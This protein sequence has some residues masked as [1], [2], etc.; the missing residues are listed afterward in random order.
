MEIARVVRSLHPWPGAFTTFRGD[1]LKVHAAEP[2]GG[3]LP[4]GAL[5]EE[6]GAIVVG[7]GSGLL[8]LVEVQIAGKARTTGEAWFRGARSRDLE[9]L[10]AG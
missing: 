3:D 9:T 10:G 6:G 2:R 1:H 4:P 8:R 5:R 7:T